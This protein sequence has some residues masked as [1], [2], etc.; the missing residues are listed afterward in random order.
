MSHA[1]VGRVEAAGVAVAVAAG[2]AGVAGVAATCHWEAGG[3]VL[4][5]GRAAVAA[6]RLD[7]ATGRRVVEASVVV[8]AVT[9]AASLADSLP[10]PSDSSVMPSMRLD[11]LPGFEPETE[12]Q[13][14][15]DF[16]LVATDEV[17]AVV[18]A[19]LVEQPSGH[20]AALACERSD[21]GR[22]AVHYSAYSGAC[23]AEPDFAAAVVA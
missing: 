21:L 9:L 3:S 2:V 19:L 10:V 12:R 1:S 8:E 17:V 4:D 14:G 18:G 16:R 15:L 6:W 23:F 11:R 7:V 13:S 5:F 20:A 22:I